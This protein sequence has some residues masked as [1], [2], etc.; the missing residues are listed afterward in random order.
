M[1]NTVLIIDDSQD[2]ILIAERIFQKIRPDIRT[3]FALSGEAGL[4][5]L[6][7][8]DGL[9]ALILIDLKMPGI[10][11][12]DTLRQIRADERLKNIP[13]IVVTSSSLESDVKESL[14]AGADFFLN[15]AFDIDQFSKDIQDVLER[16]LK[17]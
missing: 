3:E 6:R 8:G 11:G 5:R 2:D 1:N 14:A 16:W 15:K 12:F 9:P 17:K 13:V 10:G 7:H 4:A